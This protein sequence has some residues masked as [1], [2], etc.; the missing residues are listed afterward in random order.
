MTCSSTASQKNYFTASPT[1]N[2]VAK[3]MFYTKKSLSNECKNFNFPEHVS[4]VKTEAKKVFDKVT[5]AFKEFPYKKVLATIG[6]CLAPLSLA[7]HII[8]SL[9]MSISII[10]L[11]MIV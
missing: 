8:F 4:K 1:L 7:G 5:K 11:M 9:L 6:A 10:F 2:N 3:N